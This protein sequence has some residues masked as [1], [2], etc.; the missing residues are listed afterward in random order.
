MT[1][2]EMLEKRAEAV[3]LCRGILDKAEAEKRSLTA[4]ERQQYD[5]AEADGDAM[6]GKADEAQSDLDRRARADKAAAELAASKPKVGASRSDGD[7]NATR[8]NRVIELRASRLGKREVTITPESQDYHQRF[9]QYLATGNVRALQK[10]SDTA[11]GYL[12]A[13]EQFQAT[14]IQALDEDLRFRQIAN[15]LPP[16]TTAESLGAPSLDADPADPTWVSEITT[17][18][19]DSTMS[20][21][22]RSLTPAPCAQLI[23]VSKTLLRRSAIAADAIVTERLRYKL[24]RVQENAFLNGSGANQPLGVFTASDNGISTGRDASTGNTTTSIQTDGLIEAE[25]SL[26]QQYRSNLT[27]IF[28]RD[29]VKQIRKLKDGDG[30]YI[31]QRGIMAGTPDTL[32]RYPVYES[33][34]APNTFTTGLYVGILGNF[35]MYWIVDAL[36]IQIQRLEELY[37]ATNQTGFISRSETDGMPVLEAAFARVKLA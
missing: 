2:Q 8:E 18:S 37:A 29:G 31:W 12:S 25:M 21:G 1:I 22:K 32:L 26:P 17:G 35:S 36:T 13:S 5:K 28:H 3:E 24:S 19:E 15:V 27:W 4:E 9:V 10:D 34:L 6:K 14:L 20:V 11:G 7:K 16:L 30:Q 33:E 23:K